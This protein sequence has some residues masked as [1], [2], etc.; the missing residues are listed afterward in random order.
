MLVSGFGSPAYNAGDSGV[1]WFDTCFCICDFSW[2]ACSAVR[3]LMKSSCTFQLE[4]HCWGSTLTSWLKQLLLLP[5]VASHTRP[6]RSA[7][8][9]LL[10]VPPASSPHLMGFWCLVHLHSLGIQHHICLASSCYSDAGVLS[11]T[12]FIFLGK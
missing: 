11:L 1:L 6:C 9:T 7:C 4:S 12:L 5:L 3:C 10:S 2:L 8:H